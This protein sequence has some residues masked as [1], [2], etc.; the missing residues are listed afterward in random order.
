MTGPKTKYEW[1]A[2]KFLWTELVEP[3][4]AGNVEQIFARIMIFI[5]KYMDKLFPK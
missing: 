3:F 4:L 1:I 5:N 2:L